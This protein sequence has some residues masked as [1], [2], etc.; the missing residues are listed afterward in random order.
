[1]WNQLKPTLSICRK[2]TFKWESITDLVLHYKEI[3]LSRKILAMCTFNFQVRFI[4]SI[5]HL[6]IHLDDFRRKGLLAFSVLMHAFSCCS[7]SIFV[8]GL[9][10]N[11]QSSG[12]ADYRSN[13]WRKWI[14]LFTNC[15]WSKWL[16]C[17]SPTS[18]W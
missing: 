4:I 13:R 1:M 12:I 6:Y 3:I 11:F 8:V 5:S 2:Y 10:W 9:Q 7:I 16:G 18:T 17:L 14:H 15:G